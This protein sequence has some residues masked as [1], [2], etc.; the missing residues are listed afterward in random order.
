MLQSD[1]SSKN[2]SQND[3]QSM[4]PKTDPVND[5]IISVNE[6]KDNQIEINKNSEVIDS[7]TD[8]KEENSIK[9]NEIT[10]NESNDFDVN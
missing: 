1:H 3:Q 5:I 6:S 4:I 9:L 10:E 2:D 8:V 7:K